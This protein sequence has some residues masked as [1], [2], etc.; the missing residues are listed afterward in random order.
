MR[1]SK[2]KTT[3]FRKAPP[4]GAGASSP[5][6]REYQPRPRAVA[7]PDVWSRMN[8]AIQR[9]KAEHDKNI[10]GMS[11]ACHVAAFN[12]LRRRGASDRKDPVT[13]WEMSRKAAHLRAILAYEESKPFAPIR[14]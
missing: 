8:D 1:I 7:S 12:D 5:L 10:A 13:R 11:I 9:E 4:P 14:S 2:V 6:E 3:D